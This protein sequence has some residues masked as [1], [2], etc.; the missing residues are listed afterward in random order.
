MSSL[1]GL[2]RLGDRA[3]R[4]GAM[5]GRLRVSVLER[6]DRV[7]PPKHGSSRIGRYEKWTHDLFSHLSA[8]WFFSFSEA[9]RFVGPHLLNKAY[10]FSC[11]VSIRVLILN[12]W[13][14]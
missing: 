1:S 12:Q 2:A 8:P 5:L 4:R 10:R 7:F 9:R 6:A 3:R 14:Y 13:P 11:N